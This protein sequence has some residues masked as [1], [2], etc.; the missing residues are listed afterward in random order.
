MTNEQLTLPTPSVEG[1]VTYSYILDPAQHVK[2]YGS[3]NDVLVDKVTVTRTHFADGEATVD[4]GIYGRFLK[5]DGTPDKRTAR[6]GYHVPVDR[7]WEQQF[8]SD[9]RKRWE[10]D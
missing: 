9:A 2:C 8:I 3:I 10:D 4:T 1:Q 5:A 7:E 6:H